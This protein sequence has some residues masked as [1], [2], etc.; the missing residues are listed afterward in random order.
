MQQLEG[1]RDHAAK[2]VDKDALKADLHHAALERLASRQLA[3]NDIDWL[4]K[5]HTYNLSIDVSELNQ[6]AI[7]ERQ[8]RPT[9]RSERGVRQAARPPSPCGC[10]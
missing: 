4:H 1:E 6:R 10:L 9:G 7:E 2:Q 3:M 8:R 5:Q